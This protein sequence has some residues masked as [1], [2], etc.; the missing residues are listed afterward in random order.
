LFQ[1]DMDWGHAA[2]GWQ[3]KGVLKTVL[4]EPPALFARRILYRRF[5][6]PQHGHVEVLKVPVNDEDLRSKSE[7]VMTGK[8]PWFGHKAWEVDVGIMVNG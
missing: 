2:W 6:V 1:H 3:E 4:L 7:V 5:Q 8:R